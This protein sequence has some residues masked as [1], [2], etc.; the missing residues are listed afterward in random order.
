MIDPTAECLK[1]SEDMT[2]KED[3][4][5]TFECFWKYGKVLRFSRGIGQYIHRTNAGGACAYR[6]YEQEM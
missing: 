6:N 5:L 1:F 2:L 4:D 3:Y